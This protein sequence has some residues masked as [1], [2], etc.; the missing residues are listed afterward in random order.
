[1]PPTCDVSAFFSLSAYVLISLNFSKISILSLG[2]SVSSYWVISTSILFP[3]K[4]T[5]PEK[6]RGGGLEFQH[7]FLSGHSPMCNSHKATKAGQ[8]ST[9]ACKLESLSQKWIQLLF[10]LTKIGVWWWPHCKR[11]RGMSRPTWT[12]AEI[13]MTVLSVIS[14]FILQATESHWMGKWA[15]QRMESKGLNWGRSLGR[16][17]SGHPLKMP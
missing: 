17:T 1:M 4:L 5:F 2:L 10:P 13:V 7:N 6:K 3:I 12:W 16:N 8:K 9:M 11:G 14:H 15:H